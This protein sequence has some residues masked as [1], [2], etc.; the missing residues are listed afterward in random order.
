VDHRVN[1]HRKHS[2]MVQRPRSGGAWSLYRQQQAGHHR[3]NTLPRP[4]WGIGLLSSLLLLLFGFIWLGVSTLPAPSVGQAQPR[5]QHSS[6]TVDPTVEAIHQLSTPQPDARLRLGPIRR[7]SP[8]PTPAPARY[9]RYA[10][11]PDGLGRTLLFVEDTLTGQVVHMGNE[12]GTGC[13]S[14]SVS[15]R[16]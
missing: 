15:P 12:N 9:T 11:R 1:K 5:Q 4:V 3:M 6:P 16:S 13:S 10:E 8:T 7:A 2:H 14:P